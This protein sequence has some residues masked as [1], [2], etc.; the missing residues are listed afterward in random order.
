MRREVLAGL[1]LT[2][3]VACGGDNAPTSPPS[4]GIGTD[5]F[6]VGEAG[7]DRGVD[8]K[9]LPRSSN[10][11]EAVITTTHNRGR[12][13]TCNGSDGF[14]A[15]NREINTG[16]VTG[17]PRL[18]GISEMR[19]REL[20]Y[21]GAEF[22]AP[23]FGSVVIRDAATGRTKFE[24]DYN[25]WAHNDALQG[26][27]VGRFTDAAGGGNLIA[28]VRVIF[29]DNGA[30]IIRIGGASPPETRMNSGIF[31]GECS[32]MFTEYDN[33]VPPPPT[34]SVSAIRGSRAVPPLWHGFQR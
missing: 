25:A 9:G 19:I 30:A 28:N 18:A 1:A 4:S 24:G 5:D 31:G 14:Y 15:E 12:V 6:S 29:F 26:T 34:L 22:W 10:D 33:V 20:V 27:I 23:S 32:G 16:T 2:A 11:V 13:R 17:D 3:F 8:D 7:T 21:F